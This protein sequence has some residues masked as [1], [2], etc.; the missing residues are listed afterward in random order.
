MLTINAMIEVRSR[1]STK[2]QASDQAKRMLALQAEDS[3]RGSSVKLGTTQ[4]T[5]KIRMAPA[6]GWYAQIGRGDDTVGNP[7]RAQLSQLFELVLLLEVDEQSSIEQFEAAVS[8]STVPSPSLN[9]CLASRRS[10]PRRPTTSSRRR[11]ARIAPQ[12]IVQHIIL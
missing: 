11:P 9:T 1:Q 2:Q 6:Q 5:E 4:N 3:L 7:H 8:R 12:H 10:T